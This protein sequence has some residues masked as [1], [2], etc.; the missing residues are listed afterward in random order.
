MC[1]L[2]PAITS[3]GVPI[4]LCL[5]DMTSL[6]CSYKSCDIHLQRENTCQSFYSES[7]NFWM[8]QVILD[9]VSYCDTTVTVWVC[10][11]WGTRQRDIASKI[12]GCPAY[13]DTY[14]M[15]NSCLCRI[16]LLLVTT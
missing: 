6:L 12:R 1:L 9:N 16:R 8:L 15:I 2:C 14:A 5:N 7:A 4:V 3:H 13:V 11:G 10:D